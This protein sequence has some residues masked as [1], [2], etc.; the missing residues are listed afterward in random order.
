MSKVYLDKPTWFPNGLKTSHIDVGPESGAKTID[1]TPVRTGVGHDLSVYTFGIGLAA[2]TPD[3]AF[4]IGYNKAG[5]DTTEPE[6]VWT[7]EIDYTTVARGVSGRTLECY[8]QYTP[9]GIG[10]TPSQ[11]AANA[12]RPIFYSFN[13]AD[14]SHSHVGEINYGA[15]S[16]GWN[17]GSTTGGGGLGIYIDLQHDTT[18]VWQMF[19]IDGA[20]MQQ[21]RSTQD[22]QTLTIGTVSISAATRANPGQFTVAAEALGKTG[23]TFILS[24]FVD[25][26][27]TAL[28]GT[29]VTVTRTAATTYTIGVNT[30]GYAAAYTAGGLATS[31]NPCIITVASTNVY[32]VGAR[33]QIYKPVTSGMAAKWNGG[34]APN[35]YEDGTAVIGTVSASTATTLT[36]TGVDNTSLGIVTGYGWGTAIPI[37]SKYSPSFQSCHIGTALSS[38]YTFTLEV[39]GVQGITGKLGIFDPDYVATASLPFNQNAIR[40]NSL[41]SI[42]SLPG[43]TAANHHQIIAVSNTDFTQAQGWVYDSSF[44]SWVWGFG[45]YQATDTNFNYANCVLGIQA[46][47]SATNA[48][49]TVC[50]AGQPYQKAR[51]CVGVGSATYASMYLVPLAS[52]SA[53]T[54][55]IE[56]DVYWNATTSKLMVCEVGG[57]WKTVVTV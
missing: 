8:W 43:L 41:L 38:T 21:L 5:I 28:N 14:N 42:T 47:D 20:S 40:T 24:G 57:A 17:R 13:D 7:G 36:L 46:V 55:P 34:T 49:V 48:A 26:G 4:Y 10:L 35:A 9:T 39:A 11:Q 1:F 22:I 50:G 54:T 3:E 44:G 12:F 30:S 2:S 15:L 18:T 27:W 16:T 19:D 45:P 31:V 23:N 53:K 32:F 51:L 37:G 29:T 56:G 6:L 52:A 33:I 25:A